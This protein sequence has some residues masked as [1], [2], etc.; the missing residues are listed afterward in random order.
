LHRAIAYRPF[1]AYI[2]KTL[3]FKDTH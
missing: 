3:D 2:A 1:G